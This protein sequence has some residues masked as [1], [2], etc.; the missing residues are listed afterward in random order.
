MARANT[1]KRQFLLGSV[2]ALT[3]MG[4]QAMA[5]EEPS[6]KL[7]LKD[8]AC[9]VR[10]YPA[11]IA[12]EV[13]VKGERNA[14]INEAFRLLAGYIFGANTTKQKIAMTAPVVQTP[15][16]SEKIA[17][18]APVTQVAKGEAWVVRFIMP[19]SYSLETLPTP[20]NPKVSLVPIAES[21]QAVLRF[22]GLTQ[23]GDIT[24]HS[25]DLMT[26][27]AKHNL[28]ASGPVT[29]AR[30]DP[31]WTPWFMRRNEVSIIVQ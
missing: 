10:A 16:A 31:P 8:G 26:C 22:S 23:E 3:L 30:F 29:L 12:A 9:E 15:K 7:S 24:K 18:T 28:K 17:M 11:L 13:T 27:V 1:N 19:K 2:L 6:Y 21:K 4:T 25:K 14:A 5:V 20:N